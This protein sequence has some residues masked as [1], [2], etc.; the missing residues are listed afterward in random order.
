MLYYLI[1]FLE[2]QYQPAGFQ[3]IYFITVRAGL[4]AGTALVISLFAG[5]RIIRWLQ[6]HQFKEMVREGQMAGVVDHSHKAGTPTMGGIIIL[7]AVIGS[8]LLWG[9]IG[10]VYIQLII[11]ATMWMGAFGFADDYIKVIKKDKGGLR[12]RTKVTGQVSLG[13]ILGG[14]LYFHPQFAE[15]RSLTN[16]PF[17][18]DGV[19][20]YD[21]ISRLFGLDF[22]APV[23]YVLVVVFIVTALSNAAN[24]TDGLDGLA[25][26]VASVVSMGLVLLAYVA[27]NAI[28]SDFLN[29]MFIPG[30]G[31]L[32]VFAAALTAAGFGF[33]WYNGYPAQVFMGDTG[34]MA[35]GAAIGTLALMIKI[36]LLLPLLCGA[37]FVETLSV[38]IQTTWFRY[39]KKKTGTGRRVFRM[40]PIHH[41]YEALGIPES[42]IV[43]RF[44][45]VTA[46]L[47][48]AT[49][50]TFRIR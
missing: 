47:V 4:A 22:L 46:I 26:G 48:I 32:A 29:M 21:A 12:K 3:V 18:T 36:E 16:L 9:A 31:E 38:I 39:T 15:V 6:D 30:T 44:W 1:D 33:L 45:I 40:A 42:K 23:V 50:L 17:T 13:L 5:K 14:V 37:F 19:F 24:L 35:L 8:T 49:L 43:I 10:E 2:Q 41:H 7:L 11:L 34:S 28:F 20:D 25:A 27:G